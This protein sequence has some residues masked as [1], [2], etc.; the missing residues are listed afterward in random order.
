MNTTRRS[1]YVLVA[2]FM[3]AAS[4]CAEV[5]FE[6][7]FAHANVDY[8]VYAELSATNPAPITVH[9][10][11]S[12]DGRIWKDTDGNGNS[13]AYIWTNSFE[14]LLH[15]VTNGLWTLTLN[16]SNALE[17]TYQFAVSAENFNAATFG[18]PAIHYPT[19]D[20][21]L[22]NNQPTILWTGPSHLPEL[23]IQVTS[24]DYSFYEYDW[25]GSTATSWTVP[26][27]MPED[28]Y[29]A[30]INYEHKNY[31]NVVT[32]TPTNAIGATLPGWTNTFDIASY[33]WVDF[34]VT[35]PA[36]PP[37]SL[38]AALDAAYLTWTTGGDA[39]WF[40]QTTT[41]FD[42]IDAARSGPVGFEQSSWIE[43]SVTNDGILSFQFLVDAD[44]NDYLE[45]E[46][47]GFPY[48]TFFSDWDWQLFEDYFY[49]GAT[50]R[51]TFYNDDDTGAGQDTAF[52]DR[53]EFGTPLAVA[54]DAPELVW[55]SGGGADWFEQYDETSDGWDAAQ[56]GSVELYG[57]SWIETTV[58]GPGTLS[59]SW[60]IFADESD[61]LV[62]EFNSIPWEFL[63]GDWGWDTYTIDLEP[64]PNTLR[65]TFRN[66]DDFGG[67]FY[68]AGFLDE[69]VY[70]P[71]AATAEYTAEMTFAIQR[72]RQGTNEHYSVYVYFSDTYAPTSSTIEVES[73]TG[74]ISG[75][76]WWSSSPAFATLQ[77]AIDECEYDY[78]TLF[79]DRGTPNE[80]EFFFYVS[81]PFL[82]TDDLPIAQVISPPDAAAGVAA[83]PDYLWLG[84]TTYTY[85]TAHLYDLDQSETL[86]FESL[87]VTS[88][89]WSNVPPAPDGTN[90]FRIAYTLNDYPGIN[91]SDPEDWNSNPLSGWNV[92]TDLISRD[93][94]EFVVSGIV[95]LPVTL[96]PPVIAGGNL[97][98][99]FLSQSGATHVVEWSTNL[100]T[101]PWMPATNFPGSGT[102]HFVD[103]PATN[104]AAFYRV[105]T[106]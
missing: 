27:P 92:G 43:T 46:V 10:V 75:G 25:P 29:S 90:R 26:S 34:S 17:E 7:N 33:D 5:H 87:P 82:T 3:T 63:Y 38:A 32:A 42:G 96:L 23:Y 89:T 15:D 14:G 47:D 94:S 70:T 44:D 54:V 19:Q 31:T 59:F 40:A 101:G 83:N 36:A 18:D 37:S 79:Y 74:A 91:I 67:S 35:N 88:T 77:D 12:P 53:V 66:D 76:E 62:F 69:V 97:G 39:D 41:T 95:P 71:S 48:A 21:I 104:N 22:T 20:S 103:L 55:T 78:W 98:L 56:S 16:V 24:D 58:T 49:E 106:Q 52:L 1:A 72:S 86:K 60:G 105:N 84:P 45:L 64:G 65:W 100:V 68:D 57:E 93:Q 85:L 50:L 61:Y 51:W 28:A 73:Y 8:V 9:R 2:A 99:S 102:T 13:S 81:M 30:F 4:L 11:E 6:L 80:K